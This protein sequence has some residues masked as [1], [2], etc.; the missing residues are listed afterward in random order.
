[1]KS[2]VKSISFSGKIYLNVN[3]GSLYYILQFVIVLSLQSALRQKKKPRRVPFL[4]C[5]IISDKF[6]EIALRMLACRT[7]LRCFFRF[8]D[9]A[10]VQADPFSHFG[11]LENRIV[12]DVFCKS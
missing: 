6:F 4:S 12:Y 7:D 10:A 9:V 1:M 8:A 11:F 2:A 3:Y 5:L